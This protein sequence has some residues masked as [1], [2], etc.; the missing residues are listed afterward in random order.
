MVHPDQLLNRV[1]RNNHVVLP[2]D[3]QPLRSQQHQIRVTNRRVDTE[4]PQIQSWHRDRYHDRAQHHHHQQLHHRENPPAAPDAERS[5]LR[6]HGRTFPIAA[7]MTSAPR[8][9][10]G[11]K[12]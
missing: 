4:P 6:R 1:E 5:A 11:L 3:R 2:L 8:Y 12:P 9:A 7:N 10:I